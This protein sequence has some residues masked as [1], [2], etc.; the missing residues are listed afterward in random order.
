MQQGYPFAAL[1]GCP[2]GIDVV[3]FFFDVQTS[4]VDAWAG[5][6]YR[7]HEDLDVFVRLACVYYQTQLMKVSKCRWMYGRESTDMILRSG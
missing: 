2:D 1:A 5:R 4:T 7:A 3:S 6:M